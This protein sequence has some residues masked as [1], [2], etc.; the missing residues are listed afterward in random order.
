MQSNFSCELEQLII[1]VWK[2]QIFFY[3][4]ISL[5]TYFI[6]N[7]K[8]RLICWPCNCGKFGKYFNLW[9]ALRNDLR[10][11]KRKFQNQRFS[12]R[13]IWNSS[14]PPR[15]FSGWIQKISRAS[16]NWEWLRNIFQGLLFK[17]VDNPSQAVSDPILIRNFPDLNNPNNL[18]PGILNLFFMWNSTRLAQEFHKGIQ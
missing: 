9:W 16:N 18:H 12:R 13:Q 15:F 7:I 17:A 3:L 2:I 5:F 11:R 14:R 6:K 8:G 10:L 4:K 1:Q